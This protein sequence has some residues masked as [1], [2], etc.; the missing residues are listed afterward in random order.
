MSP[1]LLRQELSEV[2]GRIQV[3]P[4]SGHF[5]ESTVHG[6]VRRVLLPRTGYCLYYVFDE[7]SQLITVLSLWHSARA[8]GPD[9]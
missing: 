5:Y 3:L 8:A 2:T 7:R 9:L 1:A 4:E 6:D